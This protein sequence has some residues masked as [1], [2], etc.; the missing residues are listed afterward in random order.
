MISKYILLLC[1]MLISLT[2]CSGAEKKASITELGKIQQQVT[3]QI[4]EFKSQG[5]II[6]TVGV[7]EEKRK[8]IVGVESITEEKRTKLLKQYGQNKID[9][10]KGERVNPARN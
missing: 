8:V 2:G 6:Y 4:D 7:D 1:V 5:I 10:V 3:E 9:F